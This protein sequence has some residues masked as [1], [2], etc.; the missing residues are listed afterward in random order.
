MEQSTPNLLEFVKRVKEQYWPDW[1]Q[2]CETLAMNPEDIKKEEPV[3]T[4]TEEAATEQPAAV[5]VV[6]TTETTTVVVQSQPQEA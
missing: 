1:T 3:P 5:P 2:I 4:S 6:V